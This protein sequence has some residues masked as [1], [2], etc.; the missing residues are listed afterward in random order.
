MSLEEFKQFINELDSPY[1]LKLTA[2]GLTT[3]CLVYLGKIWYSYGYFKRRGFNNPKPEF[4][5]GNVRSVYKKKNLSEQYQEWTKTYGKIYGY[6]EGH[7]PVY[8]ISD[9]DIVHEIFI[10]QSS[11]F[12]ARKKM[13]LNPRDSGPTVDLLIA[14]QSRW[15]RM[16]MVMNP[17]FSSSKLKELDPILVLCADRLIDV[18]NKESDNNEVNVSQ[19][20]KRFTMDSIWNCAFGIDINIQYKKENE[21]FYKCEDVFRSLADLNL[22]TYVADYFHEFRSMIVDL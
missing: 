7:M 22:V 2:V 17:T 6:F 19:Y 18:L 10:K 16:R 15:K 11:N 14:T 4:L 9:L 3:L 8:V 13:H 5:F 20:M 12:A 1:I 21:Y